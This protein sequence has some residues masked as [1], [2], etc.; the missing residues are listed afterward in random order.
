M[1]KSG[2]FARRCSDIVFKVLRAWFFFIN[3]QLF[4]TVYRG[5]SSVQLF[6]VGSK[7]FSRREGGMGFC[8]TAN[9]KSITLVEVFC[10]FILLLIF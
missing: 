3:P 9:R 10:F 5:G 1:R 6:R 8:P 4:F 2:I 7:S